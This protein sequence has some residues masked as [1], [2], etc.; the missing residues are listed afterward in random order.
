MVSSING[1]GKINSQL[2]KNKPDYLRSN[3]K[4]NWKL[5]RDLNIRPEAIELLEV[6]TGSKFLDIG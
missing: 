4:I 6:N 2:Q 3:T 1:T 5:I